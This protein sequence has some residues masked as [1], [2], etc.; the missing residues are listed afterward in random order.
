MNW[1]LKPWTQK[2]AI[3]ELPKGKTCSKRGAVSLTC[4]VL[5][6]NC[7]RGSCWAPSTILNRLHTWLGL[8]GCAISW[9]AMFNK[10]S[11]Q[12][13]TQLLCTAQERRHASTVCVPRKLRGRPPWALSACVNIQCAF[14]RE[15]KK[16]LKQRLK[17]VR[18]GRRNK[19]K[20][21]YN[22][23]KSYTHILCKNL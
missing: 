15:T 11:V 6:S 2:G 9:C 3:A 17:R 10:E 7:W 4:R 13:S 14:W 18:N 22:R 5:N 8:S 19:N 16:A 23:D 1:A 12:L 20:N 21:Q